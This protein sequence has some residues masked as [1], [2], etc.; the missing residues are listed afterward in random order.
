MYIYIYIIYRFNPTHFPQGYALCMLFYILHRIHSFS[1][2]HFVQF[3]LNVICF[4]V[5]FIFLFT[6]SIC[7]ILLAG[8]SN[9]NTNIGNFINHLKI[10]IR[11]FH[12]TENRW[13]NLFPHFYGICNFINLLVN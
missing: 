11:V 10:R 12:H 1:F 2:I 3:L 7:D 5:I 6:N 4:C 13:P 9:I 8:T